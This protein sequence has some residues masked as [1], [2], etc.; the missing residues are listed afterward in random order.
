MNKPVCLITG[1]TSGLGLEAAKKLAS[2]QYNIILIG[3]D[4]KKCE[5]AK[6]EILTFNPQTIVSTYVADLSILKNVKEVAETIIL[7]HPRI[8][9]LINNAGAVYSNFELTED[10]VEKT[11]ATNHLSYYVLTLKLLPL[12]EKSNTPKII[13]VASNSHYKG[14]LDIESFTSNKKYHIMKAYMQSKL[15][16]VLFTYYL[17]EKLKQKNIPVNCLHPG[18]VKTKIGDKSSFWLHRLAWNF[19]VQLTGI[20]VEQGIKNY[21]L[22]A[23][24]KNE[25]ITT[26]KYY[27]N[28]KQILSSK[29]S[30]DKIW[31]ERLWE[32]SEKI[33]GVRL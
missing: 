25:D 15:A 27:D 11:M 26:G 3:R 5:N 1:A 30:Y 24:H 10:G 9:V 33:T 31:Q 2:L 21:I 28:G 7:N 18:R 14:V 12:L 22:L 4:S 6:K 29:L 13:N 17:A 32:W 8:D 20:S 19:F 16:N 23:T